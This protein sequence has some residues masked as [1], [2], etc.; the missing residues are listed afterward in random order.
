MAAEKIDANRGDLFEA[1]F[2]A[3]VAARFVKRVKTK[4]QKR[5]PPVT[6]SD[7]DKILTE[8]MKGGYQKNVNDV[9]SA[10]VDTVTVNLSIPRKASAF[11]QT[12]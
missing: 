5:L 6:S 2:A 3:A 10:I 12:R 9:G 11:L 4:S 1:F 7:V 8:M